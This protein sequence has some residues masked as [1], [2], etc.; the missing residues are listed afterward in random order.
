M[1]T[2]WMVVTDAVETILAVGV[3]VALVVSAAGVA[4][5][6]VCLIALNRSFRYAS[7]NDFK[8]IFGTSLDASMGW[9]VI[10]E[11]GFVRSQRRIASF[12]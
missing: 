3:D 12:S 9:R 10:G 8:A 7:I 11:I 5:V 2:R 1:S 4:D 6:E